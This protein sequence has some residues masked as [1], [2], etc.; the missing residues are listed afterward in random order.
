MGPAVSRPHHWDLDV[1]TNDPIAEDTITYRITNDGSVTELSH[2]DT[3]LS[4]LQPDRVWDDAVMATFCPYILQCASP[5]SA[6][7]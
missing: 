4:F 2:P 6:H 5:I 1:V 3:T 7:S